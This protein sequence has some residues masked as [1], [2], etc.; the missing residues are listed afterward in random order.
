VYNINDLATFPAAGLLRRLAAMFYD[1]LLVIAIV[2][3]AATPIVILAGGSP[4]P[5]WP[6][7]VFR[8][9]LLAV[10][11]VF[12]AWF[13]IHGGQTLGMRA[14]RLI[15]VA[16]DGGPVGWRAAA[17]RFAAAALSLAA[18]GFGFWWILVDRERRAWHDRLSGT[19]VVSLPKSHHAAQ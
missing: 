12:H 15:L 4:A 8:L 6:R 1:G 19:R 7:T 11:F 5:G 18:A 2:M 10:V 14:W 13:W 3:I 17:K 9:Y 16:D